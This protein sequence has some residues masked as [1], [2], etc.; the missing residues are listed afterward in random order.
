MATAAAPEPQPGLG[1]GGIAKQY[2]SSFDG[3]ILTLLFI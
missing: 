2:D 3:K 1:F